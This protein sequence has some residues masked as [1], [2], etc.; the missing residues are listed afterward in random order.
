MVMTPLTASLPREPTLAG[1]RQRRC[2]TQAELAA[3]AGISRFTLSKIERGRCQPT[4]KI[5]RKLC[6][7]L[8]TTPDRVAF[9]RRAVRIA[10]VAN[11][12]ASE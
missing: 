7:A 5:R 2:W 3:R 1:W 12:G 6:A 9:P 8:E 10:R 4:P 11:A